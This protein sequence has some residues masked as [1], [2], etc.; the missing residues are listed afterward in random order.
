M[1]SLLDRLTE[2]LKN[3]GYEYPRSSAISFLRNQGSM[4]QDSLELTDQG[5][6]RQIMSPEE[7]AIDRASKRSGRDP[8]DYEYNPETNR[9]TLRYGNS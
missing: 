7:R 8:E 1:E 5:L 9:A 4:E 2:Q 6:K 3:Q